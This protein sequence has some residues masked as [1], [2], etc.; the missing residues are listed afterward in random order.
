MIKGQVVDEVYE[1]VDIIT[2]QSQDTGAAV[3]L[4]R[5]NE[6]RQEVA[7]KIVEKAA[8]DTEKKKRRMESEISIISSCRHDNI[9]A[10]F[11]VYESNEDYS[12][13]MEYMNGGDLYDRVIKAGRGKSSCCNI[14]SIMK[15]I[16]SGIYYLHEKAR[17][18]HRDLKPENILLSKDD[19]A[20]ISDF[21]LAKA[22]KT[23]DATGSLHL[24]YSTSG[25]LLYCAPE[26]LDDEPF[27][28][29]REVDLWSAG[30]IL[31]FMLF[32]KPPFCQ[33]LDNVL[34]PEQFTD[35]VYDRILENQLQIPTPQN[36]Q[37]HHAKD[38]L[39][40]L[41]EPNPKK[42]LN[43]Q[44]ALAHPFIVLMDHDSPSPLPHQIN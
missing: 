1:F 16:L 10:C 40:K 44:L 6:T 43:A 11:Q 18:V 41:M 32:G 29:N 15:D 13:V 42:R 12:L 4:G 5:H 31:Y 25:T 26:R 3:V 17:V 33:G 19:T 24:S 30:G 9:V 27:A 28:I 39:L 36:Q 22:L 20:K 38:L 37:P 23:N 2:D 7:I 21:G 34:D 14:R 8:L 35:A